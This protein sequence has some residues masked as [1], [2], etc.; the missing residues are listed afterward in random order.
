MDRILETAAVEIDPAKRTALFHQFQRL[1]MTDLNIIPLVDLDGVTLA[2]TRVHDHTTGA[3]GV[4]TS[5]SA[6]WL[7]PA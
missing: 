1:A 4:R 5:L 6:A 7:S 3:Y 2:N